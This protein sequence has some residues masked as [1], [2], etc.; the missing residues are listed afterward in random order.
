MLDFQQPVTRSELARAL[1]VGRATL[2]RWERDGIIP[3]PDRPTSNQSLFS[4]AAQMAI[5]AQV[6][7]R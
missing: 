7:A 3:V 5:A 2:W 4:P 1:G 6:E